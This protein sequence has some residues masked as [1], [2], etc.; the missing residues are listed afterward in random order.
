MM[1]FV[2]HEPS[3][4][5]LT[6]T[7]LRISAVDATAFVDNAPELIQYANRNYELTIT[8]TAGKKLVGVLGSVGSGETLGSELVT[9]GDFESWPNPPT[10]ASGW[11]KYHNETGI[12]SQESADPYQG[13]YSQKYARVSEASNQGVQSSGI[14]LTEGMLLRMQLAAKFTGSSL[15]GRFLSFTA[16]S[17]I[18]DTISISTQAWT[19]YERYGTCPG[20]ANN[21]RISAMSGFNSSGDMWVDSASAKQVLTPS[22]TGALIRSSPTGAQSF[23]IIEAGFAFNAASYNVTVKRIY[24]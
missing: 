5:T 22:T 20:N 14:N 2:P 15:L 7:G 9:N 19:M 3:E 16:G 10:L 8:D 4:L 24:T 13:D 11:T 18:S 1:Y 12:Y 23:Q 6:I 21:Y 17:V